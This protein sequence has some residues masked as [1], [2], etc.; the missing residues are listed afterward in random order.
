MRGSSSAETLKMRTE[1][2]RSTSKSLPRAALSTART[3][4]SWRW[5]ESGSVAPPATSSVRFAGSKLRWLSS[6]RKFQVSWPS[7]ASP[8]MSCWLQRSIFSCLI[9]GLALT[10]SRPRWRSSSTRM[11]PVLLSVAIS[12]AVTTAS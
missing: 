9:T 4:A 7:T 6:G 1:N 3:I 5:R 11:N 12:R 8:S 10:E 2:M